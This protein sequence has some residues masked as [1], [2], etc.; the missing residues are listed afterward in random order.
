MSILKC[1]IS[2]ARCIAGVDAV[3]CLPEELKKLGVTR[4]MVVSDAGVAGLEKHHKTMQ[5]LKNAGL[6]PCLFD[7]VTP[8]PKDYEVMRGTAQYRESGCDGVI[9]IGG[10]SSMD[11]AKGISVM[12][13]HEGDIMDYGRST[14]NR[15]FFTHGR[16]PL[17]CVPTTTGTG[18]EISP[19]A[20]ITNT[21]KDKKS[22]VE[23]HL[24]YSDV[25]FFDPE[26]AATQPAEI[27]RDTGIDALSHAIDSYTNRK[28][29]TI[30]SPFHEVLALKCCELVARSL[31]KAIA[32]A[33]ADLDCVLDLQ[34]AAMMGGCV[35]D[36]DAGA[37]HG[38]SGVLQ[39][40]RHEM[41]HGVSCGILMPAVMQYNLQTCPDKFA[42]IAC[43]MGADGTGVSQTTL[44]ETAVSEVRRLLRDIDFPCFA[45]F[46]FSD[47]E[48]DEMAEIGASNS[49]IPL[50]PRPI[51]RQQARKIYQAAQQESAEK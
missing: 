32:C 33:G 13:R 1:N 36:L 10:G 30:N 16:E 24:F 51:D 9:G 12:A 47:A 7:A 14:P 43:A 50:N 5:L 41:T 28:M 26:F 18:S 21:K 39:K 15:K 23:D 49:L 35:L 40:Y 34:W 31:R 42:K 22:D 45:D 3:S 37:M 6:E 11:C 8:N 20:V 29:L 27:L 44:A 48:L 2:K 25:F 17:F 38:L 4:P 46:Y 19:H